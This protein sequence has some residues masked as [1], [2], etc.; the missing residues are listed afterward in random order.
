MSAPYLQYISGEHVHAGDRVQYRDSYGTVV[1]VSDGE[2]EEY[3][4]GY[5]DNIGRDRGI[6]II[7]DDGGSN[8]IGAPDETLSLIGRG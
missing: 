4:P 2:A 8:F 5:E 6:L 1:F 7:D 3:S